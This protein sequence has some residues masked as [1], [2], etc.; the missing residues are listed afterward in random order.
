VLTLAGPVPRRGS[1]LLDPGVIADGAVLLD[2]ER[3]AAVGP[4]RRIERLVRARQAR[5]LD[6]DGRVVLPGLVDAHTHLVFPASRVEEYEQRIEGASYEEIAARG[7]GI[8]STVRRLRRTTEAAL[9]QQTR[10]WLE[11]FL[12]HGTTT[13]E[14]KTGYGLSGPAELKILRVLRRLARTQ[15]VEIVSTFL[16]AHVTPPEYRGRSDEYVDW[17]CRAMIPRVA[18]GRWAEFCDVFCDRGAFSVA[19]ARRLLMA[20]RAHG[21]TPRLHAEQFSRTGAT[22]LAVELGAASADHLECLQPEDVQRLA[23]S[24]VVCTLLP[25]ASFFLQQR[26]APARRLLDAGAVV[27]LATDFNPGTS[28][29]VSLPMI[30]SLACTVLRMRPAEAI[31]AVTINAAYSLRR[32]DRLGSLEPGKQADL[33][34]FDVADYREIPYYFG[35]DLCWLTIKRGRIAYARQPHRL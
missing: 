20:G 10:G 35:V 4:R 26:F 18:S 34:V 3:I 8:L 13:L 14:A 31:A 11:R 24:N 12:A 7:G 32:A 1:A 21:L 17:L 23:R 19:Q 15:P 29:T 33:V 9:E 5:V 30:L 2:G 16:G 22:A 6:V 28:P 25:G 27:A